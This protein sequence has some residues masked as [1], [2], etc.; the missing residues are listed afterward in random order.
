MNDEANKRFKIA[1]FRK[2]MFQNKLFHSPEINISIP[3]KKPWKV[4]Q[5]IWV[6]FTSHLAPDGCSKCQASPIEPTHA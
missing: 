6:T 3:L 4:E 1:T 2:I 5:L